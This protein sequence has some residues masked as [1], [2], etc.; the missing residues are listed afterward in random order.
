MPEA[1]QPLPSISGRRVLVSGAASGIGR[2][3]AL[4]IGRAGAEV[5]CA[6]LDEEGAQATAQALGP[7]ARN[8]RLDVRDESSW[9]TAASA[10]ASAPQLQGWGHTAAI[11][12]AAPIRELD[13][14][15]W[16]EVLATDLDGAFPGLRALL[17]CVDLEEGSV[18]FLGSVSGIRAAAGAAAYRVSKAGLAMLAR[19]AA[20]ECQDQGLGIRGHVLAPAGVRTP[21]WRAS[22]SSRTSRR[23]RARRRAPSRPSPGSPGTASPG[24]RGWRAR[25]SSSSGPVRGS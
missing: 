8:L 6:D 16:R 7:P 9:R 19:V 22:A 18:V 25:S 11:A 1:A 13:P 3:A 14:G 15:V 23:P 17:P 10:L 20:K 4:A 2:A 5:W 12:R 21:L 24:A